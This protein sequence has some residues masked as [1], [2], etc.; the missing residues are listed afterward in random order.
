MR[1]HVKVLGVLYI[2]LGALGIM[3]ALFM[4]AMFGTIERASSA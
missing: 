2:A 1:T 4:T 3:F